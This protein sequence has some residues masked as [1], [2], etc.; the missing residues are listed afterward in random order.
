[1]EN[2]A[3]RA[4]DRRGV[5]VAGTALAV[6]ELELDAR[7]AAQ[8]LVLARA[9]PVRRGRRRALALSGPERI[10]LTAQLATVTAAGVPLIEGLAAI[11]ARIGGPRARA[12]LDEV[13]GALQ[14]GAPL[15]QALEAHPRAFPPVYR[16]SIVA[17]EASGA[18]DKV[19]TRLARHLEWARGMRAATLQAL[20]YPALLSL[21]VGG[22]IAI[23]LLFLL[24]RVVGLFPAGM[25]DLPTQ[26][27]FVLALS[28]TLRAHGVWLTLM[29]GGVGVGLVRAWRS[30]AGRARLDRALLALPAFG[31]LARALATGKFAGTAALLQGAGCDV[32]TVL[33]VAAG[34]CGNAAM[35]A[36][37]VRASERVRGGSGLAEALEGEREVDPLLVQLV[38]VGERSGTLEGCFERV[39]AHYDAEVPRAV[40]RLLALFEPLLLIVA[41]CVVAFLLLAALLPMFQLMESLQ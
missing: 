6:D 40:A 20:I 29:L 17:G 9:E 22:L 18:L 39:A 34:A 7:L 24:P 1:V 21:A 27:R 4:A 2:F 33:R 3:Y 23:L 35:A 8:G 12:L 30:P 15:S 32:F 37:F 28:A 5:L 38:A 36:A 11:R 25:A 10:Q 31:R 26:T 41:G 19:L 14:G 16:A 13:L